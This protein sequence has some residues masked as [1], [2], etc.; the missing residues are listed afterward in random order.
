MTEST[1]REERLARL[2]PEQRA[3][4]LARTRGR[5]VTAATAPATG[6]ESADTVACG[7][8][9]PVQGPAPLSFGQ[10]RLWFLEQLT[11]GLGV[12]NEYVALRLTGHLDL[13][14]L[15][16][17]LTGLVDRHP[18]LRTVVDPGDGSPVQRVLS[19]AETVLRVVDIEPGDAAAARP[20]EGGL[21]PGERTLGREEA[22]RPFDLENGPLFRA[23]LIRS[24]P[25]RSLLVVVNHHMAGDAWSRSVLVDDLCTGY[26]AHLDG[27][28]AAGDALPVQYGDWAAWQ[29]RELTDD[30]LADHLT[31]WEERLADAPPLLD[32]ATDR[33][34]PAVPTHRGGRVRFTL[35]A[36]LTEA[37]EG[38]GREARATPF[39]V[40]LAAWQAVLMRHSGQE[41]VVV[42]VPTAG[43]DRPELAALVGMFV[44]SLVLRAD[45][46][47]D[48]TF[49]ELLSRVREAAL[50]AL[51]HAQVP[52]EGLVRRL[53]PDRDL[54]HAPL[55]QVQFGYRNVPE[56][57]ITLPGVQVRLAELDNG[58]CRTDLSLELARHGDVTEGI[59][60]YSRDLFDE[61]SVR[62]LTDA[63]ERVLL[64]ATADPTLRLSELLTLTP[65][66][67]ALL[68]AA[69]DG[70][71]VPEGAQDVLTDFARAVRARPDAAAVGCLG[72]E[73]TF[74]ALHGRTADV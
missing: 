8:I 41:D 34:R 57:K 31:Y 69:G 33:P 68:R 62:T 60:E 58:L 25:D 3:A 46:S 64:R 44:N 48:P 42:G 63:L 19:T 74:R 18:A 30:H 10:E 45:L 59:C 2:T 1:G 49:G 36:R 55:Y 7:P 11:P 13:A 16:A 53:S 70:G 61:D 32:L 65:A 67:E 21:L 66:E 71:P 20:D 14:A 27:T 38:L 39:M 54:S 40:T 17:A 12:H 29:R 6:G 5:A 15:D 28:P 4:F 23:L 47:G 43:R 22:A 72:T 51:E 24:A 26:R 50:G 56:P 37:L 35:D 52:F 73:L 9:P